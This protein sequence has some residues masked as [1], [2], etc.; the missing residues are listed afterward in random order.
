MITKLRFRATFPVFLVIALLASQICAESVFSKVYYSPDKS[1]TAFPTYK[2][3]SIPSLLQKRDF[4]AL[5]NTN[6]TRTSSGN[7]TPFV[8]DLKCNSPRLILGT[9]ICR[10]VEY[11]FKRAFTRLAKVIYLPESVRVQAIFKGDCDPGTQ[12]R[13]LFMI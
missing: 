3:F 4:N 7:I 1:K 12:G 5:N 2:P 8:I 10:F 11:G 9:P 6:T 13:H